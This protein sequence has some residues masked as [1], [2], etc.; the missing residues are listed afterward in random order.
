MLY[1]VTGT[2]I[3]KYDC[4]CPD[5]AGGHEKTVALAQEVIRADSPQE[6]S[7]LAFECDTVNQEAKWLYLIDYDWREEPRVEEVPADQIMRL[8]GAPMLPG[9]AEAVT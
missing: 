9:L 5:C 3:L 8:N 1:Y 6:A 2:V 4:E 7:E